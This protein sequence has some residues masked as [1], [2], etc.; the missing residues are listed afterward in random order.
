MTQ[1]LKR[2]ASKAVTGRFCYQGLN[3]KTHTGTNTNIHTA[4][5]NEASHEAKILSCDTSTEL[6]SIELLTDWINRV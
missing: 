1:T 6:L 2:E 3:R 5:I 4:F